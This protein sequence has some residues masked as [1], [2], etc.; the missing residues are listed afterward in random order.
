MKRLLC[1]ILACLFF[2]SFFTFSVFAQNSSGS[3]QSPEEMVLPDPQTEQNVFSAISCVTKVSSLRQISAALHS[4][5]SAFFCEVDVALRVSDTAT[6][7]KVPL[8]DLYDACAEVPL[9]VRVTSRQA[10]LNLLSWYQRKKPS[11]LIVISSDY[12]ILRDLRSSMKD[13]TAMVDYTALTDENF[14]AVEFYSKTAQTA[15]AA[16]ASG[17]LLNASVLTDELYHSFCSRFL[18]V[19]AFAEDDAQIDTAVF[20][21]A[22]GIVVDDSNTLHECLASQVPNTVTRTPLLVAHRGVPEQA[23]ENSLSGF[24]L[25]MEQGADLL[26]VDIHL[27]SD[28]QLVLMHDS[29]VDRTTTGSGKVNTM[30]LEQIKKLHLWGPDDRF[31]KSHAQERVPTLAELFELVSDRDVRLVLELKTAEDVI[32]IL[33]CSLISEYQMEDRVNVICFNGALLQK[34]RELIPVL[35]AARLFSLSGETAQEIAFDA[36]R[37]A[38]EYV[39]A[40]DVTCEQLSRETVSLIRARG[41]YMLSWTYAQL[42]NNLVL[43]DNALLWGVSAVT[44]NDT[45]YFKGVPRR[46]SVVN[47]SIQLKK[48]KSSVSL[49]GNIVFYGN[50]NTSISQEDLSYQILFIFGNDV[51]QVNK[52]KVTALKNSGTARF[53]LAVNGTTPAGQPYILCSQPITVTVGNV[54][55]PTSPQEMTSSSHQTSLQ[56]S[57]SQQAVIFF[58][59]TPFNTQSTMNAILSSN[60]KRDQERLRRDLVFVIVALIVMLVCFICVSVRIHGENLQLIRK[61]RNRLP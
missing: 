16:N 36:C 44:T 35:S 12:M 55:Q 54:Q 48:K 19:W 40:A 52:G 11:N 4:G 14:S 33:L 37:K 58:S 8:Q 26:E 57:S 25:A 13:V 21:G 7:L 59:S 29:S 34:I 24:Q 41:I 27:T 50:Q 42:N 20:S 15:N 38:L 53:R 10:A 22:D 5:A 17:V 46:V 31:S 32:P 23:P 51:V 61:S 2:L 30:T 28:Q 18:S 49:K 1:S 56:N 9:A 60:Q 45:D 43:Q 6:S 39:A 47:R 3:L